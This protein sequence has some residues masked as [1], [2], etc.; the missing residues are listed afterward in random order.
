M[1]SYSYLLYA[2]YIGVHTFYD[3]A[4]GYPQSTVIIPRTIL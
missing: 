1:Y 2:Q 3:M 4:Y